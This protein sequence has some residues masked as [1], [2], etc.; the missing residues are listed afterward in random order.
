MFLSIWSKF[1]KMIGFPFIAPKA[2]AEGACIL[3]EMGNCYGVRLVTVIM[4]CVVTVMLLIWLL[5]CSRGPTH[6]EVPNLG[7]I[8]W[9]LHLNLTRI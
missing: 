3:A 9:Q 5:L 7:D 2:S 4:V 8:F 1:K 6:T